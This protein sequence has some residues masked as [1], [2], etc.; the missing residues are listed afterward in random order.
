MD[1]LI[2]AFR[3][4]IARFKGHGLSR[5]VGAILHAEGFSI[6]VSPEGPDGGVDIVAGTG[7]LGFE[8]LSRGAAEV[9]FVEKD[10]TLASALSAQAES[11]GVQPRIVRQDALSF[12]GAVPSQRFD[13]VFLDPPYALP[14]EPL[15]AALA[16][17]LGEADHA[18]DVEARLAMRL[19]REAE[20][21]ETRER[22]GLAGREGAPIGAILEEDVAPDR[23]AAARGHR[24]SRRPECGARRRARA[25]GRA[26][27]RPRPVPGI[28]VP[29]HPAS[30]RTRRADDRTVRGIRG[31]ER[32]PDVADLVSG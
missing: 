17:A 13:I 3:C 30:D 29:G 4:G 25:V 10:S 16:P 1:A 5:I 14:I 26:G 22:V 31:T 27:L 28:R 32:A 23:E 11:F 15:V 21:L 7:A 18:I 9:W 20:P 19:D 24:G 6:R 12:L 2:T 8:A